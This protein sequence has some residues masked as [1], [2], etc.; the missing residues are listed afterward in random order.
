MEKVQHS[1]SKQYK[2]RSTKSANI[3]I[4]QSCKQDAFQ[5]TVGC[6]NQSSID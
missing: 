2:Y 5:I 4:N 1:N 6:N 3:A